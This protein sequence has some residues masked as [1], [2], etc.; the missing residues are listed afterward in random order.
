MKGLAR[1]FI[2]ASIVLCTV[3]TVYGGSTDTIRSAIS[4]KFSQ[5]SKAILNSV[6]EENGYIEVVA[7]KG[8]IGDE[9]EIIIDAAVALSRVNSNVSRWEKV[10]IVFNNKTYSFIRQDFDTFRA[11]KINDSQF[12]KRVKKK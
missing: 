9:N 10:S 12:L 2:A 11:G 6:A 8:G 4:E 3:P 1:L 7:S 5:S